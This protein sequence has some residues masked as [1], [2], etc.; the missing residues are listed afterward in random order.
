MLD[1]HTGG[2]EWSSLLV[3]G[4]QF[5]LALLIDKRD[6][7]Q[8]DD[9]LQVLVGSMSLFPASSQLADPQPD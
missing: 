5:P 2:Q 3:H 6:L 1:V 9:A 8:V 7:V 4:P